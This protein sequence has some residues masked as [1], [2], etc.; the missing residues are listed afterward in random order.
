[1][2]EQNPNSKPEAVKD[3]AAANAAPQTAP[4]NPTVKPA[5]AGEQ[6]PEERAPTRA[7]VITN[8]RPIVDPD[9]PVVEPKVDEQALPQSTLDEMEAGRRA[10]NRNRPVASAMEAAREPKPVEAS[11]A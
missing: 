2:A 9:A 10:L 6:R 8:P 3:Q 1:M 5:S 11:K 7:G 4:P